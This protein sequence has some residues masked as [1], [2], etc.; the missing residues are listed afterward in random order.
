[1]LRFWV[2]AQLAIPVYRRPEAGAG[3]MSVR[4]RTDVG[5]LDREKS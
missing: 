2:A 4:T 3:A 1:M 5:A